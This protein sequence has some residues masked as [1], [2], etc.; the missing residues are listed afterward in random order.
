MK[1]LILVLI[2]VLSFTAVAQREEEEEEGRSFF[3]GLNIGAFKAN[4]K[5]A[6]VYN[7]NYYYHPD[8][9]KNEG[10]YGVAYYFNNYNTKIALDNYFKYSYK[11][12]G[13]P[14]PETVS[15]QT[16]FDVG[17]HAGVK[18]GEYMTVYGD[19]NLSKIN[20]K[21][22]FTVEIGNPNDPTL[23]GEG[24][25]EQIA[26]FGEEKRTNLNIG[27]QAYTYK[28]GKTIVYVNGFVNL[29]NTKL[30][31][32]YF[33]VG[34]VNYQILHNN[35]INGQNGTVDLFEARQVPGGVGFGVGI[36]SGVKYEF[37]DQFT[38]D[39]NYNAL[40]IR[41]NLYKEFKPFG[42]NHALTFRIIWG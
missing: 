1:Y 38:F 21:N 29:N 28:E 35:Y 20:I 9:D 18:L 3:F 42:L 11:I 2:G 19:L 15:Y 5:A 33:R 41:T 30:E 34:E 17:G 4:K 6:L 24:E 39:L 23:I 31:K 36:G 7:G 27:I 14:T 37:N 16:A 26:I 25:L 32:N 13:F 22:V 12:V 40:Y 10:Y 8:G